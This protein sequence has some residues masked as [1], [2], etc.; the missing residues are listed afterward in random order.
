M[1]IVFLQFNFSV[2]K[3]NNFILQKK[4]STMIM[5]MTNKNKIERVGFIGK[6]SNLE[7]VASWFFTGVSVFR[8][9]PKAPPHSLS[10]S[11]SLWVC[12]CD[13]RE[14]R[15]EN[16]IRNSMRGAEGGKGGIFL[17]FLVFYQ[18]GDHFSLTFFSILNYFL[19]YIYIYN[20]FF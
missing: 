19:L 20:F 6:T 18:C 4:K 1:G 15:R 13:V 3:Q 9:A 17:A 2:T 14:R 10:L 16:E 12:E 11:L 8:V 5:S 7:V